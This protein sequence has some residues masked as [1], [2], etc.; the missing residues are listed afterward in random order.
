MLIDLTETSAASINAALLEARRRAGSPAMGMVLTLV[1][2]AEERN[3]YDALRAATAAAREHPSRIVVCVRRPGR[4]APRL[5]AEV[6]MGGETGPGETILLRMYGELAHHAESVVL[7]LLLPDAPVVT[8]WAGDP[9]TSPAQDPLGAL[10]QRRVTDAFACADPCAALVARA[11]SYQPGDTDLA[12]TRCTS[13]RTMLAAILDEP[14]GTLQQV[15]VAAEPGTP[16]ADLLAVWLGA[17]LGV[18]VQLHVSD[19]PGITDV[20]L[21]T[22]DGPI[23][24]TRP[25]G[26]LAALQRPHQPERS[27][28]LPRRSTSE[29]IAEELRRLDPDEVYGEVVALFRD[30][31]EDGR[32]PPDAPTLVR[33][34]VGGDDLGGARRAGAAG[35]AAPAAPRAEEAAR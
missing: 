7:P 21:T 31:V 22:D 10:A 20:T 17:R 16:S 15:E 33:R 19:G 28:A 8:W 9:P 32:W 25:D 29:L 13:W 27:V 34:A 11:A 5:D 6:R 2:A 14:F 12:W 24:I 1:I 18:P 26:R 30:A 23:T 35:G 3:H 4:H